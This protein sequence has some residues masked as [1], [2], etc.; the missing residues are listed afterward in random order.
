[1][2]CST[3]LVKLQHTQGN[4]S[5]VTSCLLRPTGV[6]SNGKHETEIHTPEAANATVQSD[7]RCCHSPVVSSSGMRWGLQSFPA[8]RRLKVTV[9][10]PCHPVQFCPFSSHLQ[11]SRFIYWL[12]IQHWLVTSIP[13]PGI[14]WKY[15]HRSDK[16][17]SSRK[18]NKTKKQH[19]F[20]CFYALF[21]PP[22]SPNQC[23]AQRH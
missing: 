13:G 8:L 9:K 12:S 14:D 17:L 11:R 21:L 1:M 15:R 10:D 16:N 4:F 5:L 6:S 3:L 2:P 19:Y 7:G 20:C 23:G 22:T 18:A